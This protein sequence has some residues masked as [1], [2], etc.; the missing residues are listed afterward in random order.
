MGC[1]CSNNKYGEGFCEKHKLIYR[2]LNNDM[3]G[4]CPQ[5]KIEKQIEK[6]QEEEKKK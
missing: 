4:G 3:M 2:V 5:C 1:N 6:M